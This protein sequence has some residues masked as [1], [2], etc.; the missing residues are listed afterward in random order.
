MTMSTAF[1]LQRADNGTVGSDDTGGR[2]RRR[3]FTR[4]YK[5][6]IL[7]EYDALSD[8]GAKGALLRREGLYTSH[9]AEWRRI[10]RQARRTRL[11][12][13]PP[14]RPPAAAKSARAAPSPTARPPPGCGGAPLEGGDFC[15]PWVGT[16][17]WPLTGAPS[18]R[19]GGYLRAR[20]GVGAR[21]VP[22]EPVDPLA[23][24]RNYTPPSSLQRRRRLA[25]TPRCPAIDLRRDRPV[26]A[27]Q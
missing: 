10:A 8:P 18:L 6:A 9:L 13:G 25:V 27:R 4:E 20:H 22:D 17:T 7:H 1:L 23:D 16:S 3:R 12:G 21:W 15:W 26:R 19:R 2:P 24:I 11:P 14:P 5:R